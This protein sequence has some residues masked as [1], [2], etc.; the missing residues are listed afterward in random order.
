[1]RYVEERQRIYE[2][3]LIELTRDNEYYTEPLMNFLQISHSKRGALSQN[4]FRVLKKDT[5]N[6]DE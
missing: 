3:Y 2:S 6:S 5:I 4:Q 1:M